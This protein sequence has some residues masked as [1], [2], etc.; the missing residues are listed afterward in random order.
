MAQFEPLGMDEETLENSSYIGREP[1]GC[2]VACVTLP[3][4]IKKGGTYSVDDRKFI[5]DMLRSGYVIDRVPDQ[6][7]R[8]HGFTKCPAHA[9]P[10][11]QQGL[12]LDE[13]GG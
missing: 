5:T 13:E 11:K 9:N 1:C 2:M 6:W 7:I 12:P 10:P 8:D 4:H 3:K